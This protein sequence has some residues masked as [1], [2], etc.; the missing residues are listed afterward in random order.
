MPEDEE[1]RM[2]MAATFGLAGRILAVDV[3]DD[4]VAHILNTTYADA[5]VQNGRAAHHAASVRRLSD[6][7]L[8]VRFDRRTLAVGDPGA[9]LPLL[10]AYYASKEV[11][12][13]FAVAHPAG[14]A[15]YGA[16]VEIAGA[17]TLILGPTTIG[18]TLFA[19]HLASQGARFLGDETAV[20]D[21][22][23]STISALARKPSLRE[24][25]LEFLPS[26]EMRARIAGAGQVLETDRGRFWYALG[27][28]DL[29]G[30][31]PSDRAFRLNS[32]CIIRE[33]A[34]AFSMRRVELA[35]SLPAIMQRAYARPAQL[36]E[37]AGLRRAMRH[38]T[39]YEIALGDPRSSA[40]A[41][42]DEVRVC[43]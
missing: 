25:A 34:H 3:D 18:K 12:A 1:E 32:V 5:R 24:A 29:C 21:L 26:D 11:F 6:G 35:Q 15:F 33:R 19:L 8:H 38:V 41:F 2:R 14:I 40:L 22:R 43:A 42:L 13:R 9:A 20:L 36:A 17:A 37:I 31:A 23:S 28:D 7:R 27:S 10:S 16:L 39:Q 4:A 30:I